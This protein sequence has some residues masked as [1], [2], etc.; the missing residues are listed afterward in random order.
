MIKLIARYPAVSFFVK[1]ML[2]PWFV[3]GVLFFW[4]LLAV[5]NG[6]IAGLVNA[7]FIMPFTIA[8]IITIIALVYEVVWALQKANLTSPVESLRSWMDT[9][10]K[11]IETAE[12]EIEDGKIRSSLREDFSSDSN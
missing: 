5:K 1:E 2:E 4:F 3:I 11:K 9:V 12:K 7:F 6:I 10:V 8:S